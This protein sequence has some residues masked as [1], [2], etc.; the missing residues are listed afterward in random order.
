M[1]THTRAFVENGIVV[2]VIL[3]GDDF[4]PSDAGFG[5]T[6]PCTQNVQ[7]GWTYDGTAFTPPPPPDPPT[8]EEIR[9][10]MP[11]LTARQFRLG[12]HGNELL[13]QVETALAALNEPDRTV[14]MIEWE[15]ATSID[16]GHHLVAT[17]AAALDL[18]D[19]QIDAMWTASLTL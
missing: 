13:S 18:T 11:S 9:A 12:L 6:Y 1:A 8:P 17:L 2:N 3:V 7:I 16:R 4:D 10:L 15:Y 5:T 14:A 19:E